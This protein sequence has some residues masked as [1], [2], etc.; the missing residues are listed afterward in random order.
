MAKIKPNLSKKPKKSSDW[1][2]VDIPIA[3]AGTKTGYSWS[4]QQAPRIQPT[5]QGNYTTSK[6]TGNRALTEKEMQANK[7]AAEK[8]LAEQ[9][10][11]EYQQRQARIKESVD[12]QNQPLSAQN[13]MTQSQSTGDK[14]SLA[15]NTPFGNPTEYPTLSGYVEGLD[16]INPLKFIGDMG[17]G[18]GAVPYNVQQGNYG[19]ALMG[20]AAPLIAGA[21]AGIGTQGTKQ[22]VN[23]LVNPVAGINFRKGVVK[24]IP[25][26]TK[27]F[28]FAKF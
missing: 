15:M 12:A 16:F 3:Q 4:N 6:T 7:I 5:F 11:A 20:V 10:Q 25:G 26:S 22:F 17:S 8:R 27:N 28:K 14:M 9:R 19:Q 23:N 13:I 1:E 24:E 18:V 2:I 21:T